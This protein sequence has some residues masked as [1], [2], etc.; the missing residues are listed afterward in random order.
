MDEVKVF[1]A[2]QV[3]G[4]IFGD[5]ETAEVLQ[6][7][8]R[9]GFV[10]ADINHPNGDFLALVVLVCARAVEIDGAV[11]TGIGKFC[12]GDAH[13]IQRLRMGIWDWGLMRSSLG[14]G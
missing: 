7:A 9:L 14:L 3:A 10:V 6:V 11:K 4:D 13:K 8:D 5:L 1:G 2:G 12:G